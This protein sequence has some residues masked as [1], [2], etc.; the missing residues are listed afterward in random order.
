MPMKESGKQKIKTK[1]IP[2]KEA[3]ILEREQK[4]LI[5]I[6]LAN[7]ETQTNRKKIKK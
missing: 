2:Y 7:I 4:Q 3:L 5:G 6:W 1:K